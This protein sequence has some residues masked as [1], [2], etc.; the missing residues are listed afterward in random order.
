MAWILSWRINS[1]RSEERVDG[2]RQDVRDL[3]DDFRSGM[4]DVRGF[5]DQAAR[6]QSSQNVVNNVT[7]KAI[8]GLCDKQDKI[9]Q[10]VAD[11]TATLR[12]LTEV[13][14]SKKDAK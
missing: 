11:H 14:M 12:L 6:L 5:A 1:A 2:I 7:A 10:V 9:G 13:V 3:K 4:A 8:E